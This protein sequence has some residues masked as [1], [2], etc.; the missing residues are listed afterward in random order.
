MMNLVKKCCICFIIGVLI[1]SSSF[2]SI[3]T[4]HASGL[5]SIFNYE[6]PEYDVKFEIVDSWEHSYNM[7]VEI[8]NKS[9]DTIN[10]WNLIYQS[11]DKIDDIWNAKVE[12]ADEDIMYLTNAGW[13]K[14]IKPGET[15]SFGYIGTYQDS[16]LKPEYISV[17]DS[18]R[19][20]T[21]IPNYTVVG[22]E[23]TE[24]GTVYYVKDNGQ[25]QAYTLWDLVDIVMAGAS[26]AE[27]F[28][29]PSWKNFSWAVLDTAA[30]LPVLPSSAYVRRG[31]KILLKSDEVAKF[32]K[33]EK[34][35]KAILSAMKG[36][37]M[38]A[39]ITPSVIKEIKKA[40]K[41]HEGTALVNRFTAAADRGLVGAT[42]QEGVKKLTGRL[43]QSHLK[44]YTHEIKI[45]GPFAKCR[46]YGYKKPNGEWVF[47]YFVNNHK[48]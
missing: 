23:E 32:A 30:L 37:R 38:S 40:Y 15:I 3:S 10:D 8:T 42:N 31:G 22:T 47:D 24:Y 12:C 35:K 14:E 11:Q 6:D 41:G 34:G 5:E 43:P 39:G 25:I 48:G 17:V 13:N 33:T 4:V 1:M 16:Y 29:S 21:D 26:W 18:N 46:I 45:K 27:L 20:D 19:E 44:K 36:Y 7:N 9:E 28:A 2:G